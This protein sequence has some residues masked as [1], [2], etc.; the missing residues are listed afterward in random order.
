MIDKFLRHKHGLKIVS[1][2]IAIFLYIFVASENS[3]NQFIV[4]ENQLFASVNVTETLS[5]VPVS[6]GTIDEDKFISG[7]PDAVQVKLT[8]PR[9]VINQV[10][11]GNFI[12]ETEDLTDK[13][14]GNQYI[15]FVIPDLPPS[16]DYQV[17]PS[18]RYVRISTL[19]S[20]SYDLEYEVDSDAIE[21]GFEVQDVA[22]NVQRIELTGDSEIM[23]QVD[24]VFVMITRPEPVSQSFS[25]TYSV[26]VVNKDN[27]ILDVNVDI[28]EV[29]VDVSVDRPNQKVSLSI[30]PFGENKSQYEYNYEVIGESEAKIIGARSVINQIEQ[31]D[32]IVDVTNLTESAEIQGEP[33]LP[34]GVELDDGTNIN[35]RVT[36]ESKNN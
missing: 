24:R 36:I 9:N 6:V 23:D 25:D 7:L 17:T 4:A 10:I 30:V 3:A 21:V 12:V 35:I 34:R 2:V 16:V 18:Q 33:Q 27:E 20:E 31:L 32:V 1:L 19:K 14:I 11:D 28:S 8:G 26:R 15:R 29:K 13:P 22:L 5:N